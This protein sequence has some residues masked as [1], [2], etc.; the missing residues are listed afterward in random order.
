M[1]DGVVIT[2][3][4]AGLGLEFAHSFAARGHPLLIVARRRERLEQLASRLF[5]DH[6]AEVRVLAADLTEPGGVE[7]VMEVV[8][9]VRWDLGVLVNNAGFGSAG[10][11]HHTAPA[12]SVG[13]VRLNIEALTHLC[14]L[15][16]PQ[17]VERGRGHILNIASTA[18]F[19]PGPGMAVYC[20]TKAYVLSF[21]EA[22]A[23]E[24]APSGVKVTCYCPGPTQTEFGRVARGTDEPV[25][26]GSVATAPDVVADAMRAM[27]AGRVV[28]VHGWMNTALA[29][30][31]RFVPRAIVRDLAARVLSNGL[32]EPAD[33]M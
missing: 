8:E 21:S 15:A 11:F 10:L 18:S 31:P 4:S 33:K 9:H 32:K 13:Q 28:A 22:L 2:G 26:S 23:H 19:L 20:A 25:V 6:G 1:K 7:D 14:A 3:A 16:A 27:D 24:L 12:R 30:A 29:T 17:M 5:V